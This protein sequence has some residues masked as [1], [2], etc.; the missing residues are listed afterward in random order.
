MVPSLKVSLELTNPKF[1]REKLR[2]KNQSSLRSH[3]FYIGNYVKLQGCF[4]HLVIRGILMKLRFYLGGGFKY[5]LFSPRSLGKWSNLTSIFFRWV[6]NGIGRDGHHNWKF[7]I[8]FSP[9][10]DPESRQFGVCEGCPPLARLKN[11]ISRDWKRQ[12]FCMCTGLVET[13]WLVV[14]NI[15]FILFSSLFGEDSHFDEH[16][17][18]M[19]WSHQLAI[20]CK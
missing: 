3:E 2:P 14:S 11:A 13:I 12:F 1:A 10:W 5:L 17:F 4:H 20:F 16:I 6:M 19:G 18:Q 15:F 8:H 9:S 7:G